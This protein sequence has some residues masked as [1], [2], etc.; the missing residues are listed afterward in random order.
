[1]FQNLFDQVEI[2]R[3]SDSERRQYEES[4]KV[5]W[6]NFSVLKTAKEKGVREGMQK[7]L[8]Q[9]IPQGLQQG[10]LE[11][12]HQEKI[13]TVRRLQA[14]GLTIEQIAQGADFAVDDVRKI[15]G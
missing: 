8:E 2:A 4:K 7:G 9:G 10:K 6:D 12:V 11:G 13:D 1:M 15:L 3:Y 5:F 14:M